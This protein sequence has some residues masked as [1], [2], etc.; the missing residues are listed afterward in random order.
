MNKREGSDFT[1]HNNHRSFEFIIVAKFLTRRVLNM[2]QLVEHLG[3]FGDQQ[4][5]SKFKILMS[6]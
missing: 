5:A 1:L 2:E 4:V 3:N 6:T